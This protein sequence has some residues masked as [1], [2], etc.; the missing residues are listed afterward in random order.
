MLNI[1]LIKII[2]REGVELNIIT[3]IMEIENN[4]MRDGV[5]ANPQ[6]TPQQS[7]EYVQNIIT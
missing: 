1:M 5:M 6:S 7:L 3:Y 4:I 2:F